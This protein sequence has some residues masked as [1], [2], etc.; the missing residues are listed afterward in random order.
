MSISFGKSLAGSVFAITAATSVSA[1]VPQVATDIAPVHGLVARVMEGLGEPDLVVQ[2]GASPHGYSMRPSEARALEAAN[3]VFWIGPELAPWLE[4]SIGTL[5]PDA[6]VVE[7]LDVEGITTL[8]YREGATF[9]SHDHGDHDHEGEDHAGHD[10]SEDAAHEKHD[11]A[12]EASHEGEEHAEHDH[13]GHDHAG[14]SHDGLDPH[15]WLDPENGKVWLDVIAEELAEL[16]P[17][18]ADTYRENAAAGQEEI[19]VAIGEVE[20]ML[21]STGEISFVV[22]HDAY[23][24]FETRF[25]ISAAGAISLGDAS[26]PSPARVEE[27]RNTVTELGVT[28]VFSEPQFNQNLVQTVTEGTDAQTTVIDPLGFGLDTGPDF[29]PALMRSLAESIASCAS[30]S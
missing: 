17:E 27:V 25:D 22:F 11:H 3:A 30:S 12:E 16:D 13:G 21:S 1:D 6:H 10:H 2:Q 9:E 7:L 5:A 20:E 15:A 26:D 4:D 28:C 8:E 24:Y 23:Q 19:D 18:N 29:Y 14:H